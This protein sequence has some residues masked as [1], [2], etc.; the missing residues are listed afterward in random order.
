MRQAVLGDVAGFHRGNWESPGR[1]PTPPPR[2]AQTQGA[3]YQ[4]EGSGLA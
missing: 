2:E 4:G 3:G 1:V